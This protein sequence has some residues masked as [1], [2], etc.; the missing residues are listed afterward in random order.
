[1]ETVSVGA[2]L[3]LAEGGNLT[4]QRMV[5]IVAA[6]SERDMLEKTGS[7]DAADSEI[8]LLRYD[9]RFDVELYYDADLEFKFNCLRA[10]VDELEP[11]ETGVI[12]MTMAD[13]NEVRFIPDRS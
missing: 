4:T 7:V 9:G 13:E 6:L 12:R 2:Q 11:N 5:E 3:E 10:A 1:M 8:L